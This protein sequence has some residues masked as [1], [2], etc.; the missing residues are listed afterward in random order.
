MKVLVYKAHN[1]QTASDYGLLIVDI[2]GKLAEL[3]N[4]SEEMISNTKKLVKCCQILSI[5]VVVLEQNPKGLGSTTASL[6]ECIDEYVP[7]EKYTFSGLAESHI[8]EA[9]TSLNKRTWLVA[10]IEA[11][12]C[13]YQTVRDLLKEDLAVEVVSDCISS[14][15][16][17]NLDLAIENMR[18]E[19]AKITSVEMAIYEIMQSN[20][21]REFKEV[22][23]IIK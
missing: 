23:K 13:V 22:L 14:R 8:K 12:I 2:Q 3:V 21:A 11:H 19:G 1:M 7:L 5:P 17:S 20:K 9:I 18:H 6:R 15:R 4:N 16:K 10:G